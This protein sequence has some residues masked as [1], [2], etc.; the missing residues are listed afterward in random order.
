[1][2]SAESS[3]PLQHIAE[4]EKEG[5]RKGPAKRAKVKSDLKEEKVQARALVGISA[6]LAIG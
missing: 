3:A 5:E 1:M 6:T 4:T 2:P